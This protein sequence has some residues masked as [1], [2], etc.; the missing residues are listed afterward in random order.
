VVM[1]DEANPGRWAGNGSSYW[2]PLEWMGSA[3]RAVS[4]PSVH[5]AYAV[6]PM[7]VGNLGDL[8]FDGQTA[9][10]QRGL[11][12]AGCAYVGDSALDPSDGDPAS[13]GPFA[14][15]KPQFLTLAPW[16]TTDGSRGALRTTGAKLAP[17]SHDALENDYVETAAIA[18][19]TFPADPARA[20]CVR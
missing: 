1:Q 9:I 17:G 11:G 16:V 8:A 5:F 3:Y 18:D 10:L 19:L 20:G 7:M 6:N 12:G 4:D 14:G 2:Q 15:S 13:A